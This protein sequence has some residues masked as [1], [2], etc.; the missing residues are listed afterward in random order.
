[1]IIN[2]LKTTIR[3]I[4]NNKTISFI[5][6]SGLAIS[7]AC[8]F[9]I[10]LWIQDE[11]SYDSYHKDVDRI[12]RIA[13]EKKSSKAIHKYAST[14]GALAIALRNDYPQVEKVTRIL[15]QP[16]QIIQSTPDKLFTEKNFFIIDEDFFDIYT[17]PFVYGSAQKPFAG[18]QSLVISR[19]IALKYFGNEHAIGKQFK[20]GA[21]TLTVSGVIQDSPHNSQLQFDFLMPMKP[22]EQIKLITDWSVRISI[23]T[24]VKLKKEV[25][26]LQFEKSIRHISKVY[27]GKNM[28]QE[29]T[30][31]TFFLQPIKDIYLHSNLEGEVPNSGN[32]LYVYVFYIAAII[33]ILIACINFINLTTSRA[34]LRYKEIAM[35][36]VV[37]ATKFQIITQSFFEITFMELIAL[38]LA[39]SISEILLPAFNNFTGKEFVHAFWWNAIFLINVVGLILLINV[40][41]SIY[42]VFLY[43]SFTPVQ[44]FKKT[45]YQGKNSFFLR[46]ALV[47]FQFAL[48]IALITGTLTVFWQL[49]FIRNSDMGFNKEQILVV[50]I[51]A[52]K[53]SEL[54]YYEQIKSEFTRNNNI[55]KAC[56]SRAVPAEG[57]LLSFSAWLPGSSD[58]RKQPIQFCMV[59]ADFMNT[60]DIHMLSGRPFKNTLSDI[61]NSVI[62]NESA[63]RALGFAK[64]E[65]ALGK[66]FNPGYDTEKPMTIIGVCRDVNFESLHTRIAPLFFSMS[67]EWFFKNDQRPFEQISL[68]IRPDN[69][70]GT[71]SFVKNKYE[72]LFP[73]S[74]FK[75]FFLDDRVNQQ[76]I[77]DEQFATIFN[78]FSGFTIFIACLG[79]LG[80]AIFNTERRVKEIGIRKVVGASVWRILILM[81]K[82]F[83]KWVL[84][85]NIIAI[86]AA[87]YAMNKWLQNFAY[88]IEISWWMFALSGGLVL[89]IALVT[90]SVQAIKAATANPVKSLKYE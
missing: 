49:H 87:W 10:L 17:L 61:N 38:F 70:A 81:V 19:R 90:V 65:D 22:I 4:L 45:C 12:Y 9:L 68:K 62:I 48:S 18:K 15:P 2:Y 66:L 32:A 7:M 44:I 75:Y 79:L 55:T 30:E 39:I 1:M 35:R 53:S 89:I 36:K 74:D 37:G 11:K 3:N 43:S 34:S 56:V 42:P 80:L 64:Y 29:N 83:T 84:L 76:Y 14:T 46:K 23:F 6:I 63:S 47:I 60:Y 69:L 5:N 88:R 25:D 72:K 27:N 67:P 50:P 51:K 41:C 33:I 82:D 31:E 58:D 20:I 78:I 13:Y 8:A 26:P 59:D 21:N 57:G 71:L 85:A 24:F 28:A 54:D 40:I 86:P 16:G 73:N 77:Q 52:P